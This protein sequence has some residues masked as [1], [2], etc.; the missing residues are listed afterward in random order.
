MINGLSEHHA[1]QTLQPSFGS[2]GAGNPAPQSAWADWGVINGAGQAPLILPMEARPPA[3]GQ[4]Q[5]REGGRKAPI[6]YQK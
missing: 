6:K 2:G 3:P 1:L 5:D 4:D